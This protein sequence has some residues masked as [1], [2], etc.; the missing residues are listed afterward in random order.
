MPDREVELSMLLRGMARRAVGLRRSLRRAATAHHDVAER[1][2]ALHP[3]LVWD[4]RRGR[5]R[6]STQVTVRELIAERN[7]LEVRL[8][9]VGGSDA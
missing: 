7:A 5:W 1:W 8:Y 3:E 4:D 6:P 2:F 9:Q